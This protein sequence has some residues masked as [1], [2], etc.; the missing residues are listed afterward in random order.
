M[1]AENELRSALLAASAVTAL[2]AQRVTADRAEQGTPLPFVVFTRTG[3]EPFV[4]VD[5]VLLAT[6]VFFEVQA[7]SE[8]RTE[9]DAIAEACQAAIRSAGQQVTNRSAS[10]DPD[11]DLQA[12]ILTVEWFDQ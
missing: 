8:S 5:N 1:S 2:I 12:S 3:S 7:W 10:T 6:R 9:A 4:T 11:M